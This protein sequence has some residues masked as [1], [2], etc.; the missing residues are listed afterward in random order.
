MTNIIKRVL[1]WL[2]VL[3]LLARFGGNF[4]LASGLVGHFSG[5]FGLAVYRLL[6]GDTSLAVIMGGTPWSCLLRL[7]VW[8]L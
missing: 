2:G 4:L 5:I 7:F 3:I 1:T 6:G 8:I